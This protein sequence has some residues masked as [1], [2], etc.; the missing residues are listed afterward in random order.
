MTAF[1]EALQQRV[2]AP[3]RFS[4]V[5]DLKEELSWLDS[6][7]TAMLFADLG[8][9]QEAA[10]RIILKWI[11]SEHLRRRRR[12]FRILA[13]GAGVLGLTLL[14]ASNV[15]NPRVRCSP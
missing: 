3:L 8:S 11:V 4:S 6:R 12:G 1:E 2:P 5:D 13:A 7:G 10:R 9:P 14:V 15:N